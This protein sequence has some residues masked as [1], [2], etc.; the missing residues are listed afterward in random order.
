V[1]RSERELAAHWQAERVFEPMISRDEAALR[2]AQWE[3]AVGQAC[4]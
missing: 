4:A 2:M 1:W 3:R